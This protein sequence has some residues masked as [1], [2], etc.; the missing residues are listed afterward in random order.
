[1]PER[2]KLAGEVDEILPQKTE[3]ILA[4]GGL[5]DIEAILACGT[6]YGHTV[7]TRPKDDPC[8][9]EPV[10]FAAVQPVQQIERGQGLLRRVQ[11]HAHAVYRHHC[12]EI[13]RASQRRSI[14]AEVHFC[15][16][17]T[18]FHE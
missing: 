9:I 11:R 10:V 12:P 2:E 18:T 15:H 17:I 13:Y 8:V 3:K 4:A 1:M 16:T 7:L 14:E 6:E 5:V